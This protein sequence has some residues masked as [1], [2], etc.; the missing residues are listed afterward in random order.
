MTG[1]SEILLKP[2]YSINLNSIINSPFFI[3][4]SPFLLKEGSHFALFY[5]RTQVIRLESQDV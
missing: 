4:K 2:I 5:S 1:V 3:L